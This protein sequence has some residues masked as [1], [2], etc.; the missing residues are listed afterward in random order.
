MTEVEFDTK[1]ICDTCN[2]PIESGERIECSEC[3]TTLCKEC[4]YLNHENVKAKPYSEQFQTELAEK[5]TCVTCWLSENQNCSNCSYHIST[6]K[7]TSV[8][9][10]ENPTDEDDGTVCGDC[11]DWENGEFYK[12]GLLPKDFP[13]IVPGSVFIIEI[14]AWGESWGYIITFREF[15]DETMRV[16]EEFQKLDKKH[17]NW[18]ALYNALKLAKIPILDYTQKVVKV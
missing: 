16:I 4:F 17:Q 1:E 9:F 10:K 8:C 18:D 7:Y 13:A 14:V 11:C 5:G 12:L 2:Q 6:D 15:Y 3:N